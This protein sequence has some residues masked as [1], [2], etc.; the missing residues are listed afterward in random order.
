M[1]F[2][3]KLKNEHVNSLA[4]RTTPAASDT[5][6]DHIPLARSHSLTHQLSAMNHLLHRG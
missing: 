4:L 2:L 6:P 1:D 3:L 5:I